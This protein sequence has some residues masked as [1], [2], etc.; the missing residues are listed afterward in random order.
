MPPSRRNILGALSSAPLLTSSAKVNVM[1]A[2]DAEAATTAAGHVTPEQFGA[3][4]DGVTDDAPA[5]QRAMDA[6]A[7]RGSGGTVT[8]QPRKAY[9]CLTG[10]K[11]DA[12]YVSLDG[13]AVLDFSSWGGVCLHVTASSR[14]APGT[15][16]NNFGTKGSIGG[17]ILIRGAGPKSRSIGVDFNSP[18]TA[19]SA[20]LLISNLSVMNCGTGIRFGD[21]SYNNV[22]THCEIYDCD[23]CVDYP[24]AGDNGERNTLIGCT[25]FN[26]VRG[27]RV[28]A[29]NGALHLISCSID[30]TTVIFEVEQGTILATSCHLES[31]DW[32]DR[33]IR[34]TGSDALLRLDGGWILNVAP[35]PVMSN[36]FEVR[37]GA[38]VLVDG[39][40]IHNVDLRGVDATRLGCW[41]TG[42]GD[43][44]FSNTHSYDLSVQ[45]ARLI[46]TTTTLS[47]PDFRSDRWE[48]PVWRLTDLSGPIVSR[49]G[50]DGDNLQLIKQRIGDQT[51]LAAI[52][53]Q[54]SGSNATFVLM[55]M[56]VRHGEKVLAGFRVRRRPDRPGGDGTLFVSPGWMRLDGQDAN[57][58]P[59]VVR[60]EIVGTLKIVVSPERFMP[61]APLASRLGR[62]PPRWATHFTMQVSLAQADRATF[63]F[64]ELWCDTI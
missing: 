64:N 52:K 32:V 13:N 5:L 16:A 1:S 3:V 43:L 60:Q 34:C 6:I 44:R 36:F 48:D 26:S 27:A 39:V 46:D 25:L 37:A 62:T 15:P 19:T 11:L 59:I 54:G 40:F 63:V 17:S 55:A 12:S 24:A 22:L 20:Q 7:A 28:A 56:P 33:P 53:A 4:G 21:R 31:R 41:G 49:Q 30:Y 35:R 23:L 18:A 8:L 51:G 29:P 47:D 9:R 61:V 14:A 57:G 58:V 38:T 10:L 2:R 42:P 50:R 45:P